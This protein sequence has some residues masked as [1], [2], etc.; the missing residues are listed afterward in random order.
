MRFAAQIESVVPVCLSEEFFLKLWFENIRVEM[1][2]NDSL[3]SH[4]MGIGGGFLMTVYQ[5]DKGLVTTIDAREAAPDK[6]NK[7][8]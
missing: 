4:S 6:V 3:A 7:I 8:Y 1:P 2:F 5:K